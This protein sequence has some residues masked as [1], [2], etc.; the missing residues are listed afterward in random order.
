MP[1]AFRS[2]HRK[3]PVCRWRC[4]FARGD[5]DIA[6]LFGS[7]A[8]TVNNVLTVN[9]RASFTNRTV[10]ILRNAGGTVSLLGANYGLI[11][12]QLRGQNDDIDD[13]IFQIEPTWRFMTGS[14]GHV[15]LTGA[16]ARKIDVDSSRHTADLPNIS[17][18]FAPVVPEQGLAALTFKCDVLWSM[19]DAL[20]YAYVTP[21][22]IS[23]G[24]F[25]PRP[26]ER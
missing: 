26:E 12:R 9:T 6:R 18:I 3:A 10:D 13:L 5:Q 1:P 8:W 19:M 17:N 20:H 4:R 23:P 15:L 21:G 25:V 22:L 2:R 7:D 14:V 24:A 11:N 16:E